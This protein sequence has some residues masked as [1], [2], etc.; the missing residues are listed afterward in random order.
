MD[1][2]PEGAAAH[3]RHRQRRDPQGRHDQAA[4]GPEDR[5]GDRARALT[6]RPGPAG[7]QIRA[8]DKPKTGRR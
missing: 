7:A 2:A 8:D 4:R 3:R 6:P 5:H 1:G